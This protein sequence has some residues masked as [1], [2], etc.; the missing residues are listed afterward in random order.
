MGSFCDVTCPDFNDR[1][2]SDRWGYYTNNFATE[3]LCYCHYINTSNQYGKLNVIASNHVG[4][5]DVEYSNISSAFVHDSEFAG[6]T[7]PYLRC[8]TP[9]LLIRVMPLT[10]TRY[11]QN[12]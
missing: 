3:Y 10:A 6:Y 4:D 8:M 7:N 1:L 9:H 11:R 12:A 2:F 5:A